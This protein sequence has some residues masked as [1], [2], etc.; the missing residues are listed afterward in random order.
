M[1]WLLIV[2]AV[3]VLIAVVVISIG[4]ALPKRHTAAV[5]ARYSQPPDSLF[6]AIMDVEAG[7]SWR[8]G[9]K[10]VDVISR[11][12]LTWRES[13]SWGELTMVM[14]ESV[15]PSRVVSRIADESAGFG[16]V[17]TYEIEADG[18]GSVLTITEDGEVFSP[19]FRFMSKFVFG[20]Y[21][22]LET[23]A[24]DLGRKFGEEVEVERVGASLPSE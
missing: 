9:M 4:F 23:Y 6:R 19:V 3:V 14:D 24:A 22:A 7:P 16:G 10:R 18:N 17:W 5:R 15:A 20:H 13:A 21:K 1:K 11:E 2:V 12:P 8:T